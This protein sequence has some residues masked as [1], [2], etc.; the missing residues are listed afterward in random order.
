MSN[1]IL[2]IGSTGK[3]GS[4]IYDRLQKKG[5]DV[6]PA[7][8]NTPIPFDWYNAATWPDVL[9]GVNSVYIAFQPDLAIPTSLQIITSFVHQAKQAGVR[10]LVLLSGRGEREAEA[11]EKVIM[12]S[13]L[14]WT[15][16]R[17]SFFMQNFCEGFWVGGILSSEFVIP[18]IKAKEP[19]VD[20]DDIADIAVEALIKKSHQAKIYELTGPELLS[21]N[22]VVT[23]ISGALGNHIQ[24]TEIP[25]TEYVKMLQA[26]H[27]PDDVIWLIQYLFTEVLDGRNESVKNDIE[28]VMQRPPTSF[29]EYVQKTILAGKW[30]TH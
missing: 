21:F 1:K 23:K 11:C 13:G 3:T 15:I 30:S 26:A 12:T 5:A 14:E 7:T 17:A 10:K 2:V 28:T 19:F 16:L 6:R 9:E 20:A 4:R 29:D 8:R 18:V 24:F 27:L 22:D 25:I